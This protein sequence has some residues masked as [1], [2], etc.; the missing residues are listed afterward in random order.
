MHKNDLQMKLQKICTKND[1]RMELQKICTIFRVKQYTTDL[2]K[3][4]LNIFMEPLVLPESTYLLLQKQ[5]KKERE[6]KNNII[7]SIILLIFVFV[8][9]FFLWLEKLSH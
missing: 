8:L 7:I 6:L 5:E 2:H 4:K 3:K 1:L 9:T